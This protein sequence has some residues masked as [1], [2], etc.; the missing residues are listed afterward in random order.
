LGGEP[1]RGKQERGAGHL[2]GRRLREDPQI[3]GHFHP[4][5]GAA[6]F[7]LLVVVDQFVDSA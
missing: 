1:A 4:V 2:L 7:Y 3:A 5:E 6:K